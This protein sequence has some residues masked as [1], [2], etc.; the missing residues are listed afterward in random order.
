LQIGT[1]DSEQGLEISRPLLPTVS[2][3]SQAP[4]RTLVVTAIEVQNCSFY[5]A[6]LC[7]SAVFAVVRCPSVCL[8]VRLSVR[9]SITLVDCI[10]L[11]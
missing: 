10:H 7:V 9:L 8:I 6:M 3:K 1:W 4:N 5:R 11:A 2:D